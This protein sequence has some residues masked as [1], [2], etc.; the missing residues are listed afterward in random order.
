MTQL[1]NLSIGEVKDFNKHVEEI[2]K[3]H[4]A[5]LPKLTAA[6]QLDNGSYPFD[7]NN[8]LGVVTF[9]DANYLSKILYASA[10]TSNV[11]NFIASLKRISET[12]PNCECLIQLHDLLSKNKVFANKYMMVFNKPIIS[13]IETYI[14]T[15]SNSNSYVRARVT[16]PNTDSRTIYRILFII[17][18]RIILLLIVFLLLVKSFVYMIDIKYSSC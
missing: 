16:N 4:L 15:D 18:L 9:S 17:M 11:D 12:I 1:W 2:I 10:D 7:T 6:S 5:S 8:E 13:K 14:Q 3:Y